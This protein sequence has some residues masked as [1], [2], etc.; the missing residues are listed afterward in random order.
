[1]VVAEG[2]NRPHRITGYMADRFAV[3]VLANVEAANPHLK[4]STR[5][6][7]WGGSAVTAWLR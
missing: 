2:K 6:H 3:Q 4:F 1:M 7:R 5:C